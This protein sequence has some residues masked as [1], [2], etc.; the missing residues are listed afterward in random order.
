MRIWK[1]LSDLWKYQ[2][3]VEILKIVKRGIENLNTE[4]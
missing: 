2:S 1:Y 4:G 3:K